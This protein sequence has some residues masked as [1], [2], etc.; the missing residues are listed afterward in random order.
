MAIMR[1]LAIETS[2]D[3]TAIS[4]IETADGKTLKVLGNK[5]LSQIDIH[6]EYGG[7]FPMLAKR[8]HARAI[9]PLLLTVLEEA[10]MRKKTSRH[11]LEHPLRDEFQEIM[12][13]EPNMYAAFINDLPSV[14]TPEID[15]I[16]VTSGPGLEPALWVGINF[17]KALSMIWK[18]PIIPVNHMEGHMISSMLTE[19]DGALLIPEVQF[20]V[21]GLLVSGGHTELVLMKDWGIYEIIGETKDDAAGEAF[22][23]VARILSLPYPGG[24]EISKLAEKGTAGVYQLPRPML[25]SKDFDFSFSG[26]K[27]AVLYLAKR[28]NEE[29]G[30]LSDEARANIAR[31]FEDAV[32]DVLVGKTIRAALEHGAQTILIGGGVSAN[33]R[34]RERLTE[35]VASSL[36]ATLYIPPLSLATDNALM[37]AVAGLLKY[38]RDPNRS[39]GELKAN[40]NWRLSDI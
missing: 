22:D 28:L 34:L 32:T 11:V 2:C 24:P 6:K 25:H 14:N 38:R 1:V 9:V 8:E 10:G 13:R 36:S 33:K 18:K 21:L 12:E 30:E 5:V 17:A 40:G 37:I 20:P 29:S 35:K 4:I 16:L 19:K 26:L 7:V 3:E 15:A 23:K 27:T 31:E 39:Y